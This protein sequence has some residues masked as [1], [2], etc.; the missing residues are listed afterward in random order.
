VA[1]RPNTFDMDAWLNKRISSLH[2]QIEEGWDVLHLLCG[3]Y[4][5][6]GVRV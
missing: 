2:H 6:S 5:V 3:R 4:L 1:E